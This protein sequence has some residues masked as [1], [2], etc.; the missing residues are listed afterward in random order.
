MSEDPMGRA[1]SFPSHALTRLS[2]EFGGEG[3]QKGKGAPAP[4]RALDCAE[5]E[6]KV[7]GHCLEARTICHAR[8]VSTREGKPHGGW[9][10]GVGE[11]PPHP[12]RTSRG[13]PL[14]GVAKTHPNPSPTGD[15]PSPSKSPGGGGGGSFLEETTKGWVGGRF[16]A[17]ET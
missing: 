6:V 5:A 4:S 8:T 16:P 17:P 1:E 3:W 10:G 12:P 15:R 14:L 11:S 9:G 7:T 13:S 2:Q